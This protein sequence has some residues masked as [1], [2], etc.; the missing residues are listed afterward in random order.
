MALSKQE[1]NRRYRERHPEKRYQ[2]QLDRVNR[3]KALV[4]A[5]TTPCLFCGSE[6][7]IE[8]HHWDNRETELRV[9]TC[10][11][12]SPKFIV[13]NLQ[14]TWCLCYHCHKKL[15]K[16]LVIPLAHLYTP[17]QIKT[18]EDLHTHEDN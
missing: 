8:F 16:G 1:R 10:Y 3:G 7:S 17:R 9:S 4:A 14:K 15:H 18:G 12:K 6:D 5:N 11:H 2:I 13:E